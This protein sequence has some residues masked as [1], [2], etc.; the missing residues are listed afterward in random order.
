MLTYVKC[1]STA[2]CWLTAQVILESANLHGIER[3]RFSSA[4]EPPRTRLIVFSAKNDFSLQDSVHKH[5]RYL[6]KHGPAR[7][8]HF[9]YTLCTR[10]DHLEQ[11]TF[12]IC[13]GTAPMITQPSVRTKNNAK[14]LVFVF[15]GQGAQ[16]SGMGREL[17][18]SFSSVREDIAEMDQIL[19]QC[20]TPPGWTILGMS[21]VLLLRRWLTLAQRSFASQ[22]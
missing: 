1:L 7:L 2:D 18:N 5:A 6:E 4:E 9:A 10:R 16:W 19:S 21:A 14:T 13:D 17:I 15:T 3:S 8:Q 22:N 20:H 11:R 12:A